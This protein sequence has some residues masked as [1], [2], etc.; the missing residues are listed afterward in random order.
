[1]RPLLFPAISLS[2]LSTPAPSM[3]AMHPLWY[4]HWYFG[5]RCTFLRARCCILYFID[6][7][8]SPRGIHRATVR[9]TGFTVSST[10]LQG[11]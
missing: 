10:V 11:P 9:G 2:S 1:M 5:T 7:L 6:K 3:Q 4:F 8:A